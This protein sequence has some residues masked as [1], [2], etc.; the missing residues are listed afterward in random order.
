MIINPAK[1]KAVC[2]KKASKALHF[3]MRIL[4][5]GN[6][7]TESLAYTSLVRPILEYGAACSDPKS[8]LFKAYMGERAWEAIGDRLE[9]PCYLSRVDHDRKIRSRKQKTDIGK[10][11]FVNR[12]IQLWNQLPA[13]VL[14]A[15]S[16][17][18][19]NFRKRVR[20]PINKAKLKGG[21]SKRQGSEAK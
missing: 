21:S 9:R 19:S 11:S 17:K 4:K 5:K 15:R 10:Y 7:N 12:T 20:K 3:T 2:F 8:A 1:S 16:Y 13:D 6:S 18:P 14:G